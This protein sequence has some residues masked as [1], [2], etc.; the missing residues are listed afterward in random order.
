MLISVR[1]LIPKGDWC[2]IMYGQDVT[3]K[4]IIRIKSKNQVAFNEKDGICT[5]STIYKREITKKK[6]KHNT[7]QINYKN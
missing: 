3:P 2:K 5:F 4:W 6:K 7:M 1:S